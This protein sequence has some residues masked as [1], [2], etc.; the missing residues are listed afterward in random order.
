VPTTVGKV[1]VVDRRR[2]AVIAEV[3][4]ESVQGEE[5]VVVVSK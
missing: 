1:V 3:C 5:R 2:V 4:T